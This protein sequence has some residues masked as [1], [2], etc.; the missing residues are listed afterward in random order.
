MA[1]RMQIGSRSAALLHRAG[2]KVIAVSDIDSAVY[3]PEGLAIPALHEHVYRNGNL[4][5]TFPGAALLPRLPPQLL[6]L[7]C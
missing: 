1:T 7:A 3:N 4:L 2:G 6:L 5:K